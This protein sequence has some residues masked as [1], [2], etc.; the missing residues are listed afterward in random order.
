MGLGCRT[1]ASGWTLCLNSLLWEKEEK[2]WAHRGCSSGGCQPV[3]GA[4]KFL[5]S[6]DPVSPVLVCSLHR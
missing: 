2:I 3:L 5:L 1:W 6:A 4:G